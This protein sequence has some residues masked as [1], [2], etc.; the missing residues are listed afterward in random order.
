MQHARHDAGEN[1]PVSRRDCRFKRLSQPKLLVPILQ[2]GFRY[3]THRRNDAYGMG[4]TTTRTA[5]HQARLRLRQ[6]ADIFPVKQIEDH[7]RTLH[8]D[9]ERRQID[10]R[11]RDAVLGRLQH[12][13]KPG[14]ADIARN[15]IPGLLG[16]RHRTHRHLVVHGEDRIKGNAA[17]EQTLH[18]Q[19]TG[20]VL[21]GACEN[22]LW[23]GHQVTC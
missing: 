1:I 20:F 6:R 2:T 23:I 10:R 7:M 13:V 15:L 12:I 5:K 8:A 4:R 21:E 17:F 16:N 11:Q 14:K 9:L 19:T 22:Q 18:R 3:R